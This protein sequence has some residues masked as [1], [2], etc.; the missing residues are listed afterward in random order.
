MGLTPQWSVGSFHN[1]HLLA[2]YLMAEP[3]PCLRA[4]R[5]RSIIAYHD[6]LQ[7][8][9][10]NR[11]IL[12]N[13]LYCASSRD[14]DVCLPP[15]VIYICWYVQ[16]MMWCVT[17]IPLSGLRSS[18]LQLLGVLANDGSQLSP[19]PGIDLGQNSHFA[20]DHTTFLGE[21]CIQHRCGE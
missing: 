9:G 12:D 19:S 13:S 4:S 20:Q 1:S 7:A 2:V 17:L 11:T 21:A 15:N 18:F 5:S 3:F 10:Y 8:V 16:W 6:D 14:S